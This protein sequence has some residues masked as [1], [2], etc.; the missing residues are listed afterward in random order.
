MHSLFVALRF[1][2]LRFATLRSR[3]LRLDI[4]LDSKLRSDVRAEKKWLRM[5]Y[6]RI[7][8]PSFLNDQL[9]EDGDTEIIHACPFHSCTSKSPSGSKLKICPDHRGETRSLRVKRS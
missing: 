1:A 6:A 5:C 4:I 3:S 8:Q 7:F 2:A 9:S